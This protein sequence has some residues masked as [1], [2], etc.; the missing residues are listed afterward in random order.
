MLSIFLIEGSSYFL[1]REDNMKRSVVFFF[2]AI[3]LAGCG[4]LN[5][6]PFNPPQTPDSWLTIQPYA[7][8]QIGLREIYLVQP[9]STIFVYALG[10][11]AIG[12]GIYFLKIRHGHISRF[13]WGIALI[14]WGAGALFAGTSYEAF[15][16][17][18]KCAGRANCIWNSWWEVVYLVLSVASVD[19]MA[20]AEA[21]SSTRGKFRRWLSIY[22]ILNLSLYIIVIL[23]GSL[24][25]IKFMISFEL[26]L[27]FTVPSILMF[28]VLNSWRFLKFKGKLD[29]ALLGTWLGLG[30][31]IGVYFLY[32]SLGITQNL[33]SRGIWFSE[34]DVLHIGLIFWMLYI[35]LVVAPKME[36]L[37]ES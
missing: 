28:F 22:G 13:W 36:D 16:Y 27:I 30:F 31:I 9:S 3:L 35:G 7:K 23:I 14:L 32:F 33:W 11:L 12:V 24:I 2:S 1:E 4:T 34:N 5:T 25:P 6:I 37:A 18:I 17:E 15:S 10:I 21:H 29:L 8:I 26:L 20:F 19:A